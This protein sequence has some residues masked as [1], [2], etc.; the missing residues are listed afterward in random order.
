LPAGP[1]EAPLEP[2]VGAC[3]VHRARPVVLRVEKVLVPAPAAHVDHPVRRESSATM[4]TSVRDLA[5]SPYGRFR[6]ALDKRNA[7]AALSAAAELRSVSLTDALELCLL[8]CEREPAR[9]ER[10]ALRW[11]G[12]YCREGGDVELREAQAVV[13]ALAALRRPAAP[14]DPRLNISTSRRII[15]S[16]ERAR[17]RT[18]VSDRSARMS[19]SSRRIS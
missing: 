14:P 3:V 6:R 18:G 2:A 7:L 12:R 19:T 4:R 16:R 15:E 8:L 1:L 5:G 10:A 13:A 11:H 17:E 9:Y